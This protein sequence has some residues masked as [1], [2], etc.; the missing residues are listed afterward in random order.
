MVLVPMGEEDGLDPL[1]VL[2]NVGHI[3]DHE[4]DSQ[5]LV[6][7]KHHPDVHDETSV[8]HPDGHHI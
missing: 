2:P 6:I 8:P 3:G 4:I 1:L 5:Q 7:W